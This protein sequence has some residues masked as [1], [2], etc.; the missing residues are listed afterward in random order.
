MKS[1]PEKLLDGRAGEVVDNRI[2][3]TVEISQTDGEEKCVGR[4]FQGTAQLRSGQIAGVSVRLHP[5]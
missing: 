2:Q 1:F 4:T 3:D 5:D